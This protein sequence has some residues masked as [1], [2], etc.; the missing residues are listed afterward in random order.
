MRNECS[1]QI[2]ALYRQYFQATVIHAFRFVGNW[3]QATEAA[4]EAFRIACEKP[5]ALIH[6]PNPIGWLKNTAKNVCMNFQKQQRLYA[7]L[8]ISMEELPESALPSVTDPCLQELDEQSNLLDKE[9]LQILKMIVLQGYSYKE[10]AEAHGISVWA[11][12]KRMQRT[13]KKIKKILGGCPN[14]RRAIHNVD[15]RLK[16]D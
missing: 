16:N 5:D 8:L 12:Y 13:M 6:S 10:A 15:R 9:S 3:E 2:E 7:G 14:S 11:C 4:Q 1:E